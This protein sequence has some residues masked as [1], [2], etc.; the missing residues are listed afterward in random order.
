MIN[1]RADYILAHLKIMIIKLKEI[2]EKM[3]NMVNF[4]KELK[5]ILKNQR[6]ILKMN[7]TIS[8]L[9]NMFKNRMI[10]V[11]GVL[12]NTKFSFK[13]TKN[14]SIRKCPKG[15]R[16]ENKYKVRSEFT[17]LDKSKFTH[18][19]KSKIPIKI[20]GIIES[21]SYLC[22]RLCTFKIYLIFF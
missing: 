14:S 6:D 13:K 21:F 11:K 19:D 16:E 1:E 5:P 12:R 4:N 15:N 10:T 17:H 22:F 9:G 8:K 3:D 18:L 7:N 2:E 20:L